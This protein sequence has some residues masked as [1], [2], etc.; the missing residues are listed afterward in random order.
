MLSNAR[1]QQNPG[2]SS[3]TTSRA[4]HRIWIQHRLHC[5]NHNAWIIISLDISFMP[6]SVL[7]CVG[8]VLPVPF[9]YNSMHFIAMADQEPRT[10]ICTDFYACCRYKFISKRKKKRTNL[11]LKYFVSVLIASF[12]LIMTLL[13]LSMVKIPKGELLLVT[14]VCYKTC[15][16]LV[17]YPSTFLSALWHWHSPL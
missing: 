4:K 7:H 17:L 16:E 13:P 15:D 14:H 11:Q 2:C 12:P 10:W 5:V 6:G 8:S 9:P 3:F 1:P